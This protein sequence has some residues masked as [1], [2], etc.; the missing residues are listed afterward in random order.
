VESVAIDF[1][2]ELLT[3]VGKFSLLEVEEELEE[4]GFIPVVSV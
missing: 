4:A 2:E 1:D 3:I